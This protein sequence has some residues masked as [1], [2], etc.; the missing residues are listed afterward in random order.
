MKVLLDTHVFL[1]WNTTHDRL[2]RRVFALLEDPENTLLL[3][4][5]S[6]WEIVIKVR[7]G[8]LT[9]PE[10][11]SI[12]IPTRV[13]HYRME[14][15]PLTLSHA[16]AGESLPLLHGDPFDRLLIAQSRVEGVPLITADAQVHA[17]GGKTWW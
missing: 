17:Y 9:L 2:S 15:L 14:V 8:R 13:A 3:S 10:P 1:W 4:V 16:L 6:A 11:P 7:L 5:V 12:Y